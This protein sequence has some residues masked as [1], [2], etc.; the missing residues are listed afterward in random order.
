MEIKKKRNWSSIIVG[1]HV[2]AVLIGLPIVYQDYYYNILEVKYYYYCGCIIFLLIA[3]LVY[4]IIK[5]IRENGWKQLHIP[6]LKNI[7]ILEIFSV[8]DLMLIMFWI[9]AAIST[10]LSPFKFESFWG[11]EGRYGGLF[12]ITL[13]TAAY[14][15]I[16]KCFR[17]RS[18]YVDLCLA[19]GLAVCIFGLTDFFNLDLLGF[20]RY[21]SS[22]EKN[23]FTSFIGNINMYTQLVAIYLGVAAFMWIGTKNKLRS[24]WYYI[25]L[26]IIFLAAITGQSDNVYLSI[27]ALFAVLP[28][29]AFRSR[30][31]IR[32]YLI[33]VMTCLASVWVVQ[34]VSIKYAGQVV[35]IH[36]IYNIIAEYE[37][38]NTVILGLCAVILLLY[39]FDYVV[40]KQDAQV[41]PWLWRAWLVLIIIAALAVL[42]VLYDVNIAEGGEKYGSLQ[43]Y[44][45]F[46]DSWGSSRGFAWRI[47]LENYGKFPIHQ[48]LFGHGPD[49]FG[50]ITYFN[51][52][53]EM[54]SSYRVIFE[55]AH[56]EYLQYLMTM[57]ILGV[58]AYVG[59][60][61]SAFVLVIKKQMNHVPVMAMLAGVFCYVTQG[62]VNISQPIVTPVM[63]TL[64]AMSIAGCRKE[65]RSEETH[66][67]SEM[68]VQEEKL[69]KEIEE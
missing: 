36:S 45:K 47:A 64:L 8:P 39:V 27:A 42:Y 16:V 49:T 46:T 24:I 43:N 32:R 62:V 23:S 44:L 28:L 58:F 2:A 6:N 13:Y 38:L 60:L 1:L 11:N 51:N 19:V 26:W 57:G 18:W 35:S 53:A 15:F 37:K 20:E 54:Q 10:V 68:E 52:L 55:N 63:W 30:R 3:M 34:W 12:L 56:N 4:G 65:V 61:V 25:C 66:K 21:L 33:L 67:E 9:V 41:T 7:K 5:T 69:E 48:K 29:Y 50:L 59:L 40:K 22:S 17:V 31:G 14:F